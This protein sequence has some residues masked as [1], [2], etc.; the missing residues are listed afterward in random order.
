MV[1]VSMGMVCLFTP[2]HWWLH[3]NPPQHIHNK[4]VYR[5]PPIQ[6]PIH[7]HSYKQLHRLKTIIGTIVEIQMATIRMSGSALA[8]GKKYRHSLMHNKQQPLRGQ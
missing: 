5:Q 2:I 7:I 6:T 3:R 4:V 1:Q 8:A